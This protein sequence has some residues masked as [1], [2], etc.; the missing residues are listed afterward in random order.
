[1][2]INKIHLL[3]ID[4][5]NQNIFMNDDENKKNIFIDER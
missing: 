4:D 1:M 2:K 5:E 3:M